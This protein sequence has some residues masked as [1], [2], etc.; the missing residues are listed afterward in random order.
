M[1]QESK[2]TSDDEP[3]GDLGKGHETWKP[4]AGEQGISNRPDDDGTDTDNNPS[5]LNV[6]EQQDDPPPDDEGA[7]DE[8]L[9][10]EE[11]D[12]EDE[13]E[14]GEVTDTDDRKSPDEPE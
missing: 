6:E 11:F 13:G 8:E 2:R 4:P 7:E 5:P 12:D 3:L 9:D 14:A 10:D 1:N